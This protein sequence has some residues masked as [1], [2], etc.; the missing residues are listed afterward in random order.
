MTID[1][2]LFGVRPH[3]DPRVLA[4]RLCAE[5][6]T[7]LDGVGLT[8]LAPALRAYWIAARTSTTHHEDA[9][10]AVL[11]RSRVE[12]TVPVATDAWARVLPPNLTRGQWPH[13][14]DSRLSDAFTCTRTTGHTGRHAAGAGDC[15]VAVWSGGAR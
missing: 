13:M 11:L 1:P 8:D 7:V 9:A 5:I 4:D 15:I 2:G 3:A 12:W 14:C 10:A 6:D